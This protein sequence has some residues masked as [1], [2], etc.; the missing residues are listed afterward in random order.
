MPAMLTEPRTLTWRS[1]RLSEMQG[2]G[3]RRSRARW[4]RR[5]RRGRDTRQGCREPWWP[6]ASARP[7]PWRERSCAGVRIRTASGETGVR[8]GLGCEGDRSAVVAAAMAR[9][10]PRPAPL[11]LGG[12]PCTGV[13]DKAGPPPARR[14]ERC[15]R[16]E[17]AD[18]GREP[19]A[20]QC[21]GEILGHGAPPSPRPTVEEGE[22]EKPKPK[23]TEDSKCFLAACDYCVS[24]MMLMLL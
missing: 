15:V 21:G 9:T 2:D 24:V 17:A 5:C 13:L 20:E 22:G 10:P 19:L 8:A 14:K 12:A 4:R 7:E 1:S 23:V 16:S 3:A 6:A 18:S 11:Q